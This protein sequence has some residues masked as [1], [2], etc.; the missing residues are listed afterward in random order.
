MGKKNREKVRKIKPNAESVR[1]HEFIRRF[2]IMMLFLAVYS[3]GRVLL[4]YGIDQEYYAGMA[5]N[6]QTII[7]QM[8]SGDRYQYSIMAMGIMPY[9][10]ASLLVSFVLLFRSSEAKALI[11]KAR[12]DRWT[13]RLSILLS[14][15][16]SLIR[17]QSLVYRDMP[18]SRFWLRFI[19]AAEM[20]GGAVLICFLA[21]LNQKYGIGGSSPFILVNIASGIGETVSSYTWT[22]LRSI[23]LLSLILMVLAAF[24]EN[25]M[26]RIPV[27]RV[28]IHSSY[29]DQSYIAFKFNP[30]G[31]MPVMFATMVLI[32]P[33]LIVKALLYAKPQNPDLLWLDENLVLTRFTGVIVYLIIIAGLNIAMAFIVLNPSEMAEQLQK[34]GDSIIGVY[35]GKATKLYLCRRLFRLSLVSGILLAGGM[36]VSLFMALSGNLQHDLAMLPS[37]A[38]ILAGL[39]VTLFEEAASYIRFDR[40]RFTLS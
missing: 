17:A 39:L 12:S 2:L 32:V 20:T 19:S 29:T 34:G 38:M 22:E 7:L 14:I 27:Q 4:L 24:A 37:T 13:I 33:Q 11:S 5:K 26:I 1:T 3:A 16:L 6:S 10:T 23:A 35:A 40:Y 36:S 30:V 15:L 31:L 18:V 25:A 8:V 9:I 21:Q 28:S